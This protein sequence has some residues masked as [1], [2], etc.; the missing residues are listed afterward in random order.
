MLPTGDR[1]RRSWHQRRVRAAQQ[2]VTA[3]LGEPRQDE[4]HQV[5]GR[6][7]PASEGQHGHREQQRQDH[8][9]RSGQRAG[10]DA[11][12]AEAFDEPH[13]R[14][15]ANSITAG[16]SG[17]FSRLRSTSGW[18]G[19]RPQRSL[20]TIEDAHRSLRQIHVL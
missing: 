14:R 18:G 8:R 20:N 10:L 9:S 6:V 7:S 2:T 4:P 5:S 16:G 17:S 19:P 11:R 1:A 12:R 13:C 15:I 3:I